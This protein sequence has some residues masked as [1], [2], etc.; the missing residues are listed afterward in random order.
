MFARSSVVVFHLTC[1]EWEKSE[2][3]RIECIV[4]QD[5]HV[6]RLFGQI[7]NSVFEMCASILEEWYLT[8]KNAKKT[9]RL[10]NLTHRYKTIDFC[11]QNIP[12]PITF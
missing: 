7:R 12:S 4:N 11:N 5:I 9:Y 1:K 6:Q 3:A 8:G 10:P 2:E